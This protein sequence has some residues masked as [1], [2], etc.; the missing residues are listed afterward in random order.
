MTAICQQMTEIADPMTDI[1]HTM[2]K[3]AHRLTQS[4][5]QRTES[6]YQLTAN[7]QDMTE[8]THEGFQV[9]CFNHH[10]NLLLFRMANFFKMS[11]ERQAHAIAGSEM[12]VGEKPPWRSNAL[13]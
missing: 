9:N 5:H 11:L 6:A 2:T 8:S 13:K 12:T 7:A 1:G 4:A 3:S 10:G